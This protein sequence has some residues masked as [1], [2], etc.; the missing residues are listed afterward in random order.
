MLTDKMLRALRVVERLHH[1][2]QDD[3]ARRVLFEV[4]AANRAAQCNRLRT[5][6]AST[7]PASA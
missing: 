1:V 6:S 4:V 7:A 5:T 3:I 2:E